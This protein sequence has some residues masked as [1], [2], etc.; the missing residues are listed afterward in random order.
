MAIVLG[1]GGRADI[2]LSVVQAVTIDVVGHHAGRDL[3][4]L[5]VHVNGDTVCS[6]AERGVALGVEGVAV[7]G[8]VPLV[9]V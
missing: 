1:A 2:G 4:Y 8:D 6:S 7:L 5:A 9:L 3:H